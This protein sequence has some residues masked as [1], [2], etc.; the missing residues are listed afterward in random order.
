[1]WTIIVFK[2]YLQIFYFT[3]SACQFYHSSLKQATTL[4]SPGFS[5]FSNDLSNEPD[6]S[7]VWL[8]WWLTETEAWQVDKAG[9]R[10]R[11]KRLPAG[12]ESLPS[13]YG[14]IQSDLLINVQKQQTSWLV[15][16]GGSCRGTPS[17]VWACSVLMVLG[18]QMLGS[19]A[20]YSKGLQKNIRET[21]THPD[22]TKSDWRCSLL[23]TFTQIHYF[24]EA[25]GG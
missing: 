17:A 14:E 25:D 2:E 3:F 6:G 8:V 11:G 13:L 12:L 20:L 19:G 5:H 4:N 15:L 23:S 1:M 7:I 22:E 24:W 10:M 18:K 16:A 21:N 9:K